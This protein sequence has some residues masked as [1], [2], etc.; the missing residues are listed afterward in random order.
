MNK[1]IVLI[2]QGT[3]YNHTFKWNSFEEFKEAVKSNKGL[4]D[5]DSIVL[6]AYI[7]DNLIDRG[8]SFNDT[9]KKLLLVMGD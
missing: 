6:E 2:V 1:Y 3:E 8:N 9:L 4:P 7:D 5:K